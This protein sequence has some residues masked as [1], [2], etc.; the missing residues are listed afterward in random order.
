[1]SE[2]TYTMGSEVIDISWVTA[3][4]AADLSGLSRSMI[5]YL[6]RE[7]LVMASGSPGRHRGRQRRYS[8]G[9]VVTLRIVARLLASGIEVERLRKA[10]RQLQRRT[11]HIR[12]E[13]LPFR[14]LVTNGQELFFQ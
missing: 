13:S 1:M 7:K 14:Y 8:F 3:T 10:L 2:H 6:S 9:D 5:D 12:P 11:K 4:R